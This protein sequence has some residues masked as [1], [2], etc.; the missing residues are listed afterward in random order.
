[1]PSIK[2]IMKDEGLDDSDSEAIGRGL[3]L[4]FMEHM[5]EVRRKAYH[6]GLRDGLTLKVAGDNAA[7]R[8][9]LLSLSVDDLELS[10]R[11]S[12]VLRMEGIATVAQFMALERSQ[13]MSFKNAGRRT[14]MEISDVQRYLSKD[15]RG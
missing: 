10:V 14:W 12:N 3:F 7:H 11:T 2:E 4:G 1:M 15:G 6:E 13:V 5:K 8:D 9:H